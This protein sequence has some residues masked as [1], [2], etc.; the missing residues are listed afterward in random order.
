MVPV[1]RRSK[2]KNVEKEPNRMPKDEN[3]PTNGRY[4]NR[5]TFGKVYILYTIL[6]NHNV[7]LFKIIKW[8]LNPTTEFH[9]IIL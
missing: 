5:I 9:K 8:N 6:V 1:V 3:G 7:L 4:L 2:K